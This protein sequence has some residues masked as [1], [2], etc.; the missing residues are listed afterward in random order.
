MAPSS[1]LGNWL[2]SPAFLCPSPSLSSPPLLAETSTRI[3]SL[4]SRKTS[5][6]LIATS[7]CRAR[8]RMPSSTSLRWGSLVPTPPGSPSTLLSPSKGP[9]SASA[10]RSATPRN[11]SNASS[12][13]R[14]RAGH[15][16]SC[17]VVCPRRTRRIRRE[18]RTSRQWRRAYSSL[19]ND[20]EERSPL[21]ASASLTTLSPSV[22]ASNTC[23]SPDQRRKNPLVSLLRRR[24]RLDVLQRSSWSA[25]QTTLEV[26]IR[27]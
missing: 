17:P 13:S 6:R 10:P 1:M 19:Q 22:C 3:R 20:G 4:H 7:I 26:A 16:G 27:D 15:G 12:P 5:N 14:R 25:F 8:T 21:S 23:S 24:A 11:R 9:C 2:A 18:A